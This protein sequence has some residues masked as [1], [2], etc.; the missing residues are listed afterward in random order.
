MRKLFILLGLGGVAYGFYTFYLKQLEI[1]A[2]FKYKLKGVR[3]LNINLTNI[4]LELL[5]EV[6]N[7][8]DIAIDV[9]GY[10]LKVFLNNIFVGTIKNATTNQTLKRLGGVSEF[11]LKLNVSTKAFIGQGLIS[12]LQENF[13]NS[14]LRIKGT[15]G[16]KKSFIKLKDL[17]I[18]ETYK[19][20]DFM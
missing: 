20:K 13:K 9:S 12:G 6:I 17:P 5:V 3:I 2:L 4:E 8:S 16:L 1:L 14:T 11:P 10:D 15:F 7:D 18:D 19:M